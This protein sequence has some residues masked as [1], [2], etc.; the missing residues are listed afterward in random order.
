MLRQMKRT[1]TLGLSLLAT[2]IGF[3]LFEADARPVYARRENVPCGYCHLSDRGGGV[4]GFRGQFYGAN[5]L[6]FQAFEEV[7]EATLAR[8]PANSTGAQGRPHVA[9]VGNLTGPA[10]P[11]IQ[12]LSLDG[13]VVVIFVDEA[14]KDTR[15]AAALFGELSVAL[16]S[17]VPVVGVT[18]STDPAVAQKL[19]TD[20]GIHFRVLPDAKAL[21]ATKFSAKRGLDFALIK[22]LGDP[23][24][25][26]SGV[27]KANLDDLIKAL[28]AEGV[29]VTFDT[30]AAPAKPL[31]GAPLKSG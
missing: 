22:R 24:K 28:A 10:A 18:S 16:G 13:P 14:N 12:L 30:G 17:K 6:S 15:D 8:V 25:T 31:Q 7:R 2:G 5:G 11:Q 23:V 29:T 4:R 19:T 3:T 9:Y 20:L 27:S 21:A 26:W 1:L